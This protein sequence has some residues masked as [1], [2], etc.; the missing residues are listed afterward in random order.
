MTEYLG[1]FV[2]LIIGSFFGL[3]L[4]LYFHKKDERSSNWLTSNLENI[5]LGSKFPDIFQRTDAFLHN[6]QEPRNKDIP[7]IR[8]IRCETNKINPDCNLFI[9]FRAVDLGLNLDSTKGITIINNLNQ[10]NI[11]V[12]RES[13]GWFHCTVHIPIDAP[14]GDHKLIFKLRDTKGN[15]NTHEFK[16]IV[17]KSER[18]NFNN[19]ATPVCF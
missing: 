8:E 12:F 3:L 13:F 19:N 1:E 4:S 6:Y 16:Y 14:V 11:P 18:A 5:Y 7:Y 17:I 2:S 9:L 15:E 10:Y